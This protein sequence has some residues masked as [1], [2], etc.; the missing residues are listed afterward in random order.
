MDQKYIN[1]YLASVNGDSSLT[2]DSKALIQKHITGLFAF[3]QSRQA[4]ESNPNPVNKSGNPAVQNQGPSQNSRDQ[5][6]PEYNQNNQNQPN[7]VQN[8]GLG[9]NNQPNQNQ[10]RPVNRI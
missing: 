5:L 2:N 9:Q 7:P 10:P 1:E 6:Q 4:N 8:Q 3:A